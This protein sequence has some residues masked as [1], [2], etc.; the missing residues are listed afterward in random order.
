MDEPRHRDFLGVG[1]SFPVSSGAATG[2]VELSWFEQDV[3]E[4][5]RIILQ[6]SRGERVM[7]PRFGCGIHDL[8][9]GEISATTIAAVDAAVRD[10]LITYEPR[11]ELLNV[12]V[13]PFDALNGLLL[14]KIDYRI[15]R[16]NQTDN[17]V[18]PFYFREGGI[19]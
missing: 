6:T 10:S 18:Y 13:D 12:A 17:L 19:P 16:T 5:I 2:D 3:K 15:R 9:F 11:I 8:V 4:A 1:W 7:R 14:V